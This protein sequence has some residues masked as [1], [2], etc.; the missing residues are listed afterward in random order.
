MDRSVLA[1][2]NTEQITL[3]EPLAAL[4]DELLGV[5]AGWGLPPAERDVD[6]GRLD[7]G[8]HE[9]QA[10]VGRA[11]DEVLR[12]EHRFGLRAIALPVEAHPAFEHGEYFFVGVR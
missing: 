4:G 6:P 3:D 8:V 1:T 11:G 12:P 9:F 7:A 10:L 5:E 2:A